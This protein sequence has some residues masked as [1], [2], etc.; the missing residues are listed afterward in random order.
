LATGASIEVLG[1]RQ[2]DSVMSRCGIPDEGIPR[3]A[4]TSPTISISLL[5]VCVSKILFSAQS[6]RRMSQIEGSFQASRLEL[7][8]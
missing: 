3:A 5:G 7:P 2:I 1:A 4:H 6:V 8:R